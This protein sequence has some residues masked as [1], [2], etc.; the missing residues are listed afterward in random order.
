MFVAVFT[1]TGAIAFAT[2]RIQYE[3]DLSLYGV[4]NL[5]GC[6]V[7]VGWVFITMALRRG[8]WLRY[9]LCPCL[10]ARSQYDIP[11]DLQDIIDYDGY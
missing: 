1:T 11:P 7:L 10:C 5:N 9:L 6:Y 3:L 8:A 2:P 4:R